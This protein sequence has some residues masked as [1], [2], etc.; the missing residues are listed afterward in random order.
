MENNE[1]VNFVKISS[2]D[3]YKAVKNYLHNDIKIKDKVDQKYIDDLLAKAIEARVTK[4]FESNAGTM[5]RLIS[6]AIA[7]VIEKGDNASI[8]YHRKS[9]REIV[10]AQIEKAVKEMVTDRLS[11]KM[12]DDKGELHEVEDK[13]R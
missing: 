13:K 2:H 10:I 8:T 5:E 1:K 4:M 6:S 3:L 12:T 7:E 11:I 9:F